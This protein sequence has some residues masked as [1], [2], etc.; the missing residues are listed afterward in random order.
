MLKRT[1]NMKKI[2]YAALTFIF[3]VSM[4][5]TYVCA[6]G[7]TV[8]NTTG[9]TAVKQRAKRQQPAVKEE[10]VQTEQN[11]ASVH[12]EKIG[13][14]ASVSGTVF[15][16]AGKT[17]RTIRSGSDIFLNE[18]IRTGKT[19]SLQ[20]MLLDETVF[21][22]GPDS[23]MVMD[24]FVY[25]PA[26]ND[27]KI[28]ANVAKGVF[29]FITGKIARKDPEKMNV[30]IT[31][32]NIGIRG[33]IVA[34][35]TGPD[36]STVILAGPGLKNNSRERAGAIFVSGG[37]RPW[38]DKAKRT[39]AN[40]RYINIP[41]YGTTVSPNGVVSAPRKMAAEL[42]ELN[43]ILAAGPRISMKK[44]EADGNTED[45]VATEEAPVTTTSGQ[46]A[47]ETQ[48]EASGQK[49]Q[50]TR[51]E[52]VNVNSTE[53]SLTDKFRKHIPLSMNEL[54][55]LAGGRNTTAVYSKYNIPLKGT[56]IY[57]GSQTSWV[58]NNIQ[59]YASNDT[60]GF[61]ASFKATM[62]FQNPDNMTISNMNLGFYIGNRPTYMGNSSGENTTNIVNYSQS[63]TNNSISV[64]P[65]EYGDAS[66][67]TVKFSKADF[68][69]L[70]EGARL[71]GSARFSMA[72]T[73]AFPDIDLDINMENILV[74][75]TSS[76]FGTQPTS[77]FFSGNLNTT[78]SSELPVEELFAMEHNTEVIKRLNNSIQQKKA[79]YTATGAWYMYINNDNNIKYDADFRTTVNFLAGTFSNT[80]VTL[81]NGNESYIYRNADTTGYESA[82]TIGST[83]HGYNYVE[84]LA[85]RFIIKD[86]NFVEAESTPDGTV[87]PDLDNNTIAAEGYFTASTLNVPSINI[88]LHP[89]D[90]NTVSGYNCFSDVLTGN[91]SNV[92]SAVVPMS[93]EN[94]NT[95]KAGWNPPDSHVTYDMHYLLPESSE[96]EDN[97]SGYLLLSKIN[98]SDIQLGGVFN[99]TPKG[100]DDNISVSINDVIITSPVTDITP[101]TTVSGAGNTQPGGPASND[102]YLNNATLSLLEL[103]QN[104][105]PGILTD[106]LLGHDGTPIH[107][108]IYSRN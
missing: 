102:Y 15:S 49:E 28:Y 35:K 73:P 31:A 48:E 42:N 45:E 105:N 8:R 107:A 81:R 93:Q 103:T 14:A 26:N 59:T 95:W 17:R 61:V 63:Q 24:E 41:G 19:G 50:D 32:G 83:S 51:I 39:P 65:E 34:G 55:N 64:T 62:N 47:V 54:K 90:N 29:R 87:P 22:L 46:N 44:G 25:N 98:T 36:G 37:S 80:E 70:G 82:D 6:A 56:V 30:K 75:S 3:L 4:P 68:D 53:Y 76:S 77:I 60:A 18:R 96:F 9:K 106:I 71:N 101:Y 99:I 86:I 67:A 89:Q 92:G 40:G 72:D 10:T 20:I 13:V 108:K 104:K 2:F 78:V 66:I 27:G 85:N 97:F 94:F 12:G 79:D 33:T 5:Q 43:K 57:A 38:Y 100:L 88:I 91:G 58:P 21:T 74:V 7:N 1:E 23:D 11:N 84:Y 69:G 52:D 16:G